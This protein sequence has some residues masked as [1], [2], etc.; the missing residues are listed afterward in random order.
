MS[1]LVFD[2]MYIDVMLFAIFSLSIHL[3]NLGYS[4]F[5]LLAHSHTTL[6]FLFFIIYQQPQRAHSKAIQ[7]FIIK[8]LFFK[9]NKTD[10]LE[11][12]NDRHVPYNI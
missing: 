3:G 6:L 5:F 10:T 7:I 12:I 4:N 11:I 2:C 1:K 8:L 9:K